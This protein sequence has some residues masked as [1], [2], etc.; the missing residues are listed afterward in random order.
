MDFQRLRYLIRQVPQAQML[1][2]KAFAKATRVTVQMTDDVRG[3]GNHSDQTGDGAAEY[4]QAKNVLDELTAELEEEQAKLAV[5]IPHLNDDLQ[6][7]CMI[8]RYIGGKSVRQI[9]IETTYTETYIF[10]LLKKAEAYFYGVEKESDL[11]EP[12]ESMSTVI[13]AKTNEQWLKSKVMN[14]ARIHPE[15]VKII[16]DKADGMVFELPEDWMEIT[17]PRRTRSLKK[18]QVASANMKLE[19]AK[20]GEERGRDI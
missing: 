6:R 10:H 17:V 14:L 5:L 3:K 1:V 20:R 8:E 9:A 19:A 18:D 12:A 15:S 16:S 4:I 13:L 2:H 11:K 7:Y